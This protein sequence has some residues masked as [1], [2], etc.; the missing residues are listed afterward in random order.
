MASCVIYA[1]HQACTHNHDVFQLAIYKREVSITEEAVQSLEAENLEHMSQ[2]FDQ[3][4]HDLQIS[5]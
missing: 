4:L 2:L 1:A 5:R 3:R